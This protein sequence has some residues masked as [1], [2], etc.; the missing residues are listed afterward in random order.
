MGSNVVLDSTDFNSKLGDL[1]HLL[2]STDFNSKLGDLK[3]H[4]GPQD[5]LK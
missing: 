1:K 5:D 4:R 3:H 2:D